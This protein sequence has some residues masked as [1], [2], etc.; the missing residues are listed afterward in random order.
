M[1]ALGR[2]GAL[3]TVVDGETGVLFSEPTVDDLAAALARVTALS[4]DRDQVRRHAERFSRPRH[5]AA[6]RQA[7]DEVVAA[8]PGTRW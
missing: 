2:G 5:V 8:A 4:F 1:V 3:E 6:M 7:I